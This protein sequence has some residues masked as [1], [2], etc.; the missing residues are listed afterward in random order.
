MEQTIKSMLKTFNNLIHT[1]NLE[2]IKRVI[3]QL[4]T[5]TREYLINDRSSIRKMTL[6]ACYALATEIVEYF[7][8]T[9]MANINEATKIRY[10]V[11][12]PLFIAIKTAN[13]DLINLLLKHGANMNWRDPKGRS[14]I[15]YACDINKMEA[16]YT[17]KNHGANIND[18][19]NQN[20]CAKRFF[21]LKRALKLG[22]DVNDVDEKGE[23]ILMKAVS[24]SNIDIIDLLLKEKADIYLRCYESGRNALDLA[25][26]LEKEDVLTFFKENSVYSQED[27]IISIELRGSLAILLSKKFRKGT[28]LWRTAVKLR[29]SHHLIGDVSIYLKKD[30]DLPSVESVDDCFTTSDYISLA[31]RLVCRIIPTNQLIVKKVFAI[32]AYSSSFLNESLTFDDLKG[33]SKI[34]CTLRKPICSGIFLGMTGAI[35]MCDK[36]LR[37]DEDNDKRVLFVEKMVNLIT[38]DFVPILKIMPLDRFLFTIYKQMLFMVLHLIN[39]LVDIECYDDN[40]LDRSISKISRVYMK[41]F[42]TSVLLIAT[43]RCFGFK[44]VFCLIAGGALTNALDFQNNTPL[45]LLSEQPAHLPDK[46]M[47]EELLIGAGG[48]IDASNI[49]GVKPRISFTAK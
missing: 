19:T 33:L 15:V 11:V 22:T 14:A 25:H 31:L 18:N 40:S 1:S 43:E 10:E 28:E 29:R 9:F 46:N 20:L 30:F 32:T 17:L 7:I 47:I 13:N 36:Q 6:K 41:H 38:E 34:N 39:F 12:T 8:I 26:S 35:F 45:H 24:N 23:T 48:R 21:Y 49:Y 4:P 37:S 3:D 27:E 42:P 2:E 44:T 16:A 5:E